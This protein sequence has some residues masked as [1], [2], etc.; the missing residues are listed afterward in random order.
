LTLPFSSFGYIYK[1]Y[2]KIILQNSVY[3]SQ[4]IIAFRL[5]LSGDHGLLLGGAAIAIFSILWIGEVTQRVS[6]MNGTQFKSRGEG[7]RSGSAAW[8]FTGLLPETGPSSLQAC[9]IFKH[10]D[11][12]GM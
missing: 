9:F 4:K 7:W 1:I 8:G 6:V 12:V 5:P 10:V 2:Q 3:K 11:T